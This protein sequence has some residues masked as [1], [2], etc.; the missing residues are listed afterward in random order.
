MKGHY[1]TYTKMTFYPNTCKL[2]FLKCWKDNMKCFHIMAL[3]FNRFS[4]TVCTWK[5]KNLHYRAE[6]NSLSKYSLWP[7]TFTGYFIKSTF[8]RSLRHPGIDWRTSVAIFHLPFSSLLL[9]NIWLTVVLQCVC[10][11]DT[12]EKMTNGSKVGVIASVHTDTSVYLTWM[13]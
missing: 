12:S 9:T 1:T 6:T 5:K 11:M 2:K 3:R 13:E 4:L 10:M 7:Q 8:H